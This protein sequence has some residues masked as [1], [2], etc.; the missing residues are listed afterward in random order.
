MDMQKLWPLETR[1]D[2]HGELWLGG[3]AVSRLVQSYGTPL[4]IFDEDTLRTRAQAYRAALQRHYPGSGQAAYAAKAYLSVALAQLFDEEG[5]DL[6]VV[7]AGELDVALAAG[8]PAARIH[9]H[10]NN[11]SPAELA[12]ALAVGVGRIVVDNFYEL[13]TLAGLT[14]ARGEP[15]TIWLRLSPGIQ[16]H[17]HAHI[18]TGHEDT[19]FG[20]SIHS[21]DAAR[22]VAQAMA[23]PGL[24]LL[25]FHSH[26]GSQ[27]Y[28]TDAL[29]AAAVRLLAFA[30]QM[31]AEHGFMLAELSPGGGWGV[32]MVAGDPA[33]PID[34]YVAALSAALT[35]ACAATGLA[36]P[37]LV[38]EPGRSLVAQAGVAVYTVGARKE[39]PGVRTY[40]SVDG[41]MADNIRPALYGASYT[42]LAIPQGA[43]S[44]TA[45]AGAPETGVEV[46]TIAGKF[47][48]SGDVLI[49]DLSL[50][51][52]H[53][54]DL[55]AVPMA[56]AYTLAMASNYNLALRP[57]V[58]L[59]KD[60]ATRLMQRRETLADLTARDVPLRAPASG[61]P[62]G[63]RFWKYQ[64]VGNDYLVIDPA[65]FPNPPNPALVRRLCDRHLGIGSDGVLWGPLPQR[66]ADEAF[67]LRLYNPDGGEFEKSGNGLRIFARYLWD[68]GFATAPDFSIDTPGGRVV[69]HVQDPA[70]NTI[71]ME[72]GTL[73]FDSRVIP[74]NGGP[75]EVIEETIGVG[76][77]QVCVTAVGIGNPHCVQF[78][79]NPTP[80]LAHTLG[81]QLETY[82]LFPNRTNVQFAHADD[83]HNLRIE[84]WERG[85]G[86]TL[87]S[88]TSSCAAAGAA[89]RTGRCASPV[90]VHMPG[91]TMFVEI[92]AD[93]SV[94]LTGTVAPVCTGEISPALL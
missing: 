56:G 85:A 19:K 1:R 59:V 45:A 27:I 72:M 8:F 65:D 4:Y 50:P 81:P 88:G 87:A 54:G 11:K 57:A 24:S 71:A 92:A 53:P 93:W 37:H 40:V 23:A 26:I 86:Y 62:L 76:G 16:A 25:G 7:S 48:E 22:A 83:A 41:G 3:C 15:V 36:L 69:A 47:C 79:D 80:E 35:E 10:G 44:G 46:V 84:I 82:G 42:A 94:R 9:F 75:R 21:G 5:L 20:F 49:R 64:A 33:A 66:A 52:L 2:D 13:E 77:Q 91:G 78:V 60:G 17:T 74:V 73:T 18:Q 12:H 67:T 43:T 28:E 14:A 55:L 29:A 90:T 89:V 58:L 61:K 70:G 31:Q 30:A 32:P 68:R 6:D 39:V 51:R 34:A 38:L 63:A